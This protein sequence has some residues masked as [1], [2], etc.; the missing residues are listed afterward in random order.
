MIAGQLRG[1]KKMT[2]E[3][4]DGFYLLLIS[5]LLFLTSGIALESTSPAAMQDFRVLY[6]PA[7]CL[8]QHCDPYNETEVLRV[9][10]EINGNK[11]PR[12]TIVQQIVTRYIYPPTTFSF[13]LLF[14]ILPWEIART[15]WMALTLGGLVVSSFLIWDLGADYAPIL[16]GILAGF[17]LANCESIAVSGNAAG[18]VISLCAVAVWCFLREKL[19]PLGILCLAIS[20]AIKPHDSGPIWSLFLLVGGVYRKRALQ[21]LILLAIFSLPSIL[22]VWRVSPHWMYEMES[23]ISAFS[24]RGGL[25]DPSPAAAVANG[26]G[27]LTSLQGISS[28]FWSDPHIYNTVAY[29]VCAPLLFAWALIA[30]RSRPSRPGILLALG[31]IAAL[32]LLPVYHRQY[33][34]KLLLLAIPACAMLWSEGGLTSWAALLVSAAGLIGTADLPQTA[35][36]ALIDHFGVH[37]TTQFAEKLA[38]LQAFPAPLLVTAMGIF[39]LL[40][41]WRRPSGQFAAAEDRTSRLG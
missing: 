2:R 11:P 17:L 13:T 5:A 39:Y 29:L 7:R 12:N 35:F 21:I 41:Y 23:N 36:E 37:A 18:I 26:P 4:L 31:T 6:N 32:S 10:R 14:A 25:N 33:D 22:L 28:I 15:L 1:D 9:D 16:S 38:A 3:R 30:L 27:M 8:I 40:I 19:V 24:T 34:A 20:I